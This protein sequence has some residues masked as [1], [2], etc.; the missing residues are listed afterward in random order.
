[1][2][3][4][5][6]TRHDQ[7]GAFGFPELHF[8]SDC[9]VLDVSGRCDEDISVPMQLGLHFGQQVIEIGFSGHGLK[10]SPTIG[11]VVASAV[12]GYEPVFDISGLR[13]T[14]F[15]DDEPM[16]LAYGPSARA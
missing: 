5:F 1:M 9:D 10:L 13:P 2:R 11:E 15:A 7:G 6:T 8:G 3:L 4:G 16:Y 12:L 14:R